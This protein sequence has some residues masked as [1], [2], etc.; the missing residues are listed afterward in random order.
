MSIPT[1]AQGDGD[2][3]ETQNVI[4]SD[5]NGANTELQDTD[6]LGYFQSDNTGS[7]SF[8]KMKL[9]DTLDAI[10]MIDTGNTVGSAMDYQVFK[11]L[12][13]QLVPTSRTTASAAQG[14]PLTILGKTPVIQFSFEG[15]DT[16]FEESFLVINGLSHQINL[17]KLFLTNHRAQHDHE[18]EELS[19][20]LPGS[21]D[22]VIITLQENERKTT[23]SGPTYV[24]SQTRTRIPARSSKFLPVRAPAYKG[25]GS[26]MIEPIGETKLPALIAK[27]IS[28]IDDKKNTVAAIFNP[29]DKDVFVEKWM[30]VGMITEVTDGPKGS[31]E[32][33]AEWA[34]LGDIN[35]YG[36]EVPESFS[37]PKEELSEEDE[38][39][40]RQWIREQFRLE[41]SP[42]LQQD[43]K[44][45]RKMEDLF[46]EFFDVL[47]KTKT[48]Y[49]KTSYTKLNIDLV[50]GARPFKGRARAFNPKQE[51]D[52]K[53]Q[54]NA[55][56][57]EGVIEPANSP[58]GAPLIPAL[59]K[60]GR[61]RWCVDF[62]RLNDLTIKDSFPLPLIMAN[63]HKLGD[64]QIY[65][66]LDGTGAY[67]NI[68]IE[69]AD[70]P[71]TA[72][73]TPEAQWQFRRMPFG[74]SN[75]PQAYCR[76]IEMVLRG[77]D[78]RMVL[79]YIDDIII[80]TTTLKNHFMI[81]RQVL[82]AHRKA[83]LK[84]APAKSYICQT[85]VNYLGHQVSNRGIEMV[86][87][88]VNLVV[89]WPKPRTPK[90]LATFLGKTGYYRQFVANYSKIAACLEGEKKKPQLIWT[91]QMDESF[92]TLKEAFLK[93]P[94]LA[95]PQFGTGEPFILD[96]DWCQEGMAQAL[97]QKQRMEDGTRERLIAAGGRKCTTAE[98]N[99]ASNKGETASFVDGLKR[100]EHILRYAPFRARVDNKCLSYIR[101]LK[102]PTGIWSRWLELIDSYQFNIEHRAGSKHANADCLSRA[103]HLP[104]PTEEQERESMEFIGCM[105]EELNQATLAVIEETENIVPLSNKQIRRAQR[106]D[107]AVR[108]V[109]EWVKQGRK[110]TK[111][112]RKLESKEAQT[113]FQQYEL[114][115]MENNILYRKTLENEH[116]MVNQDRLCVPR[117][118]QEKALF[119][120][121][122]HPSAAHRGVN[123][124]Q[125]RVR[126][127]FYFPGMYHKVETYVIG[128]HS[129]L[130]KRGAP[131]RADVPPHHTQRGFPGARWSVDL[132]GPLPRTEKG[133]CYIMTAEDIFTRWPIAVAIPDKTAEEI[134]DAFNK[135]VIAEHGSCEELL[136]DNAKELTGL[137][138]NDVAKTLGIS[139]VQTVP[140]NP[141]GN[142]VERYHRTLGQMLRTTITGS[143]TTWED[144]LPYTLMAYRTSVHNTTK[145]TP[146][147]LMHG[148]EAYLPV[149][150]IFPRPPQREPLRT[151]YG[152][153][154]RTNLEEAFNFVREEQNK[155]IKRAA[156]L[157]KGKLGG[158][159]L[160]EGDLVWYYSPRRKE[161]TVSKLHRG[162]L[163][164]F[165]VMKVVSEVTFI[166]QPTGEWCELKPQIPATVHRLKRYCPDTAK[167]IKRIEGITEKV[168]LEELVDSTDEYLESTGTLEIPTQWKEYSHPNTVRVVVTEEQEDI[169]DVGHIGL[170]RG[171]V[172]NNNL[173]KG[174]GATIIE[175]TSEV[176]NEESDSDHNNLH[177][178]SNTCREEGQEEDGAIKA[179][180]SN[181]CR[182][183]GQEEDGAT[184]AAGSSTCREEGQEV[185]ILPRTRGG[186]ARAVK[187]KAENEHKDN[188]QKE[189]KL[190][191]NTAQYKGQ[192]IQTS[193][194][195]RQS[196]PA[197]IQGP[198]ARAETG[199]RAAGG[200]R[201]SG[202]NPV[203]ASYSSTDMEAVSSSTRAKRR[204]QEDQDSFIPDY[205][206]PSK[207][208]RHDS[209]I[210]S[211]TDGVACMTI[212]GLRVN[213][214]HEEDDDRDDR[215]DRRQDDLGS[216]RQDNRA[217]GYRARD[218]YMLPFHR[219]VMCD[220]GRLP[221]RSSVRAAAVDCYA[222]TSVRIATGTTGA[223]P[224]GFELAPAS[225]TYAQLQEISTMPVLKP[226]LLLRAGVI[227][228]DFRGEVHALFTYLGKEDFAYIEKGERVAQ[229]VSTCFLTSP[230]HLVARLPYSGRGRTAGYLKAMEVVAPCPDVD[231]GHPINPNGPGKGPGKGPG[232]G[233]VKQAVGAGCSDCGPHAKQAVWTGCM[234]CGPD[235]AW[236]ESADEDDTIGCS[237]ATVKEAGN[238]GNKHNDLADLETV[239]MAN[240]TG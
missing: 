74:L 36:E 176:R 92:T 10:C 107:P 219:I 120:A 53:K 187:N 35:P 81:M 106:D 158:E 164:P 181:M 143:Q 147:Y 155:V 83:G 185:N 68:E 170:D 202:G 25:I 96:A 22:P 9:A 97:S 131:G 211:M 150:V 31:Q 140:Y 59:K 15:S 121:H 29:L 27:S 132:V 117:G 87:D 44:S 45:L 129:C 191:D 111:E 6:I 169:V 77:I 222:R 30:R 163:G 174:N 146:F 108:K 171:E 166:I 238:S 220:N 182:E 207:E 95:F 26:V 186:M 236:R 135:Y 206:K 226:H 56:E 48:D 71:L 34:V 133:N 124:T 134:A 205:L 75:A 103:P 37:K 200:G 78:T 61:T 194:R 40:R 91:P 195:S 51:E 109:I 42:I 165:K 20:R 175:A 209:S 212:K 13:L 137:V 178:A 38:F 138:I 197:I 144:K 231:L 136:T 18:K 225:G 72:F 46:L 86:D 161:G 123:A 214:R 234:G 57:E 125:Q 89:N 218:D 237:M 126:A 28:N 190:K 128:C 115:Y 156:Q 5:I 142:K 199:P 119:W 149:D 16:V 208:A 228:P 82:E 183:E 210:N 141:N 193:V 52:L 229:M 213:V 127:R 215:D 70:R 177:K 49:G 47:S 233:P 1:V 145:F 88:Y 8:K 11:S 188:G 54:L 112:E 198:V 223:V 55:W 39:Q 152:V 64:S 14:A 162:W 104:D 168:L 90:E 32:C 179:A 217:R 84:I 232:Q 204:R 159:E 3:L 67:H 23:T 192:T 154:M 79:A 50:P 114:L 99:Y 201:R 98:R 24:Y 102:K 17:G 239:K 101:N 196:A 173:H 203:E 180:G 93:K 118:L 189:K 151:V 167:Q 60:D 130:Q 58:W 116:T 73:L 76:L 240:E 113:Y 62:R 69:E 224:L 66:T 63:L 2:T 184:K 230:F 19:L 4:K 94:I 33:D 172:P 12:Q 221:L 160:K 153:R 157:Y 100:F 43:R 235:A 21:T 216:R 85:K 7:N 139:K 41:D 148:R 80:H 227:D 110:P 65:T 105:V 122:A